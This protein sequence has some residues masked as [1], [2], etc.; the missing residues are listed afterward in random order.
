MALSLGRIVSGHRPADRCDGTGQQ[1][2]FLRRRRLRHGRGPGWRRRS[3]P[4]V[5]RLVTAQ[6][7]DH[8]QPGHRLCGRRHR[9]ARRHGRRRLHRALSQIDRRRDDNVGRGLGLRLARLWFVQRHHQ[10]RNADRPEH[11]RRFGPELQPRGMDPGPLRDHDRHRDDDGH[12]YQHLSDRQGAVSRDDDRTVLLL[13]RRRL[14]GD[15]PCADRG[16]RERSGHSRRVRHDPAVEFV[17]GLLGQ[18]RQ[19]GPHR[20]QPAVERAIRLRLSPGE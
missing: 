1:S 2:Q 4:C 20:L 5:V 12:A 13:R 17:A 8:P 15:Q 16:A 14:C 18:Q 9:H 7:P 3:H 11:H 19:P 10:H 6:Q